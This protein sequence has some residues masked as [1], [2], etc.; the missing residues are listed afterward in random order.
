MSV[1]SRY[2]MGAKEQGRE[3]MMET[4]PNENNAVNDQQYTEITTA[5]SMFSFH[6][7]V[8]RRNLNFTGCQ[9]FSP[10]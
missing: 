4:A 7:I 2:N 1:C 8:F 10:S 9:V 3:I 6:W 5:E